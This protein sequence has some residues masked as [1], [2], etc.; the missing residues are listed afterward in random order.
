MR[1]HSTHSK[2]KIKFNSFF[3]NVTKIVL[4]FFVDEV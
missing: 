2:F 3:E 1:N 4:N